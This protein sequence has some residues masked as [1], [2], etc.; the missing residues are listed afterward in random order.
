MVREIDHT[1]DFSASEVRDAYKTE[2]GADYPS[3][4]VFRFTGSMGYVAPVYV[5]KE[6]TIKNS[7]DV[8]SVARVALCV[9]P[10]YH[11]DETKSPKDTVYNAVYDYH[12]VKNNG[13]WTGLD[14]ENK[15]DWDISATFTSSLGTDSTYTSTVVLKMDESGDEAMYIIGW[16][17]DLLK[18]TVSLRLSLWGQDL[19]AADG[20]GY[21]AKFYLNGSEEI[22][23][24]TDNKDRTVTLLIPE[25]E[26][27]AGQK[28][29]KIT[30]RDAGTD[31]MPVRSVRYYDVPVM[32]PRATSDKVSP[33]AD[34]DMW[35]YGSASVT[36][37]VTV[38]NVYINSGGSLSVSASGTL[39]VNGSLYLRCDAAGS[40][41]TVA[42][43]SGG[44]IVLPTTAGAVK[45][46]RIVNNKQ[47]YMMSLPYDCDFADIRKS[48]EVS[49]NTLPTN[50]DTYGS[51]KG[52]ELLIKQYSAV[53][54]AETYQTEED[55]KAHNRWWW[56][57]TRENPGPH[58]HIWDT[59]AT[60]ATIPACHGF[61]I[62]TNTPY[63]REIIFSSSATENV[64]V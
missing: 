21:G 41:G 27:T 8:D 13:S 56:A 49:G 57:G 34:V 3:D 53:R 54:R 29:L 42:V 25:S 43:A 20:Y 47:W 33:S 17:R 36:S 59:V 5:V 31:G 64:A 40:A 12:G 44:K 63:Y 62:T 16:S 19:N 1:F 38:R 46:V 50:Q 26:I 6:I 23:E 58:S 48:P 24:F 10:A 30:L 61:E 15:K 9:A 4:G 18:R 11:C 45:F 52:P 39:T 14:G 35:V 2:T 37:N 32:Y 7:R 22:T 28:M 51:K 55:A 60:T